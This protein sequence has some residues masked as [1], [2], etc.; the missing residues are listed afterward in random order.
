MQTTPEEEKVILGM[1]QFQVVAENSKQF[2]IYLQTTL[3]GTE[4][5]MA[6]ADNWRYD[7]FA[8]SRV[9][10]SKPSKPLRVSHIPGRQGTRDPESPDSSDTDSD[11]DDDSGES[12]ADEISR[13]KS[14]NATTNRERTHVQ[15]G[16]KDDDGMLE[17]EQFQEFMRWKNR[18]N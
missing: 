10:G 8:A 7:R 14:R 5:D 3:G 15:E 16:Q 4:A 9:P 18:Q 11:D 13:R 2:D 1:A 17:Y 12:S 6:F